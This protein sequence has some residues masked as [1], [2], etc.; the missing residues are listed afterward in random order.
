MS[1]SGS[2]NAAYYVAVKGDDRG[3]G[4]AAHPFATLQ[5][6]A[7]AMASSDIKTTIISGGA[8]TGTLALGV[9]DA[10]ESFVAADGETVTLTGAATLVALKAADHVTLSGLTF[11][12][13]GAGAAV[14]NDGG[15]YGALTDST[16]TGAYAGVVLQNGASHNTISGNA[17]R[18]SAFAAI[19]VKDGSD[20]NTIDGNLIDGV[21]PV[22][23][24]TYGGGIYLHGS[25]NDQI[26]RNEIRGTAGTA[27]NLSDFN[28]DGSTRNL[29]N[30][31]AGNTLLNTNLTAEDSG[32]IY[33]L[34][35]SAAE[36]GTLVAMNFIDGTGRADRHSVG[37]Y[38]DDNANG[39]RVQDNV[40]RNIG[41]DGVQIHGGNNNSVTGNV[42]D[43]GGGHAA[44]VLFQASPDDQ[45]MPSS[46]QNNLVSGNVIYSQSGTPGPLYVN[47]SDQAPAVSGNDYFSTVG[48]ALDTSPDTAPRY[49]DP[50]FASA[51]TGDY[52]TSA[53]TGIGFASVGSPREL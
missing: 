3:D 15:S 9:A 11:A 33:I 42:I 50:G 19:E 20:W 18:D 17:I 36:T 45:R 52:R 39:V 49:A 44:A 24:N 28:R 38:L 30:T 40:I 12:G 53:G 14:V 10:G 27:I 35:R 23:A 34:G 2:T 25:S 46:L 21:G 31:I 16:F 41:S 37:V 13:S 51:A 48:V 43:L 1:G 32:S 47:L 8:Y 22:A 29:N 6:A 7:A 5:R 26:V 4:S